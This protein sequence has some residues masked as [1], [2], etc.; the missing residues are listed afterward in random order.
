MT[1]MTNADKFKSIFG[2]YATE[3]W[4]KPEKDFLEWLNADAELFGNSEQL[5]TISRQAAIDLLKKWS[6]G[7]SYIEVETNSAIKAFEEIPSAQSKDWMERN[8]ERIL[9]AGI[10]GREIECRIGGRLFAIREKAQ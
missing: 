2:L 8:K 9:Q 10:E 1:T 5:D 7:Y 6:D 4:A 3:L